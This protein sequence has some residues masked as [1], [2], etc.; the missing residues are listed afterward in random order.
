MKNL[1]YQLKQLCHQNRDGGFSTQ[2]QRAWQLSL[3]ANQLEELG[4]RR[5]GARSLKQKHVTALT[6]HWAQ[7]GISIGTRKNRLST[8]RW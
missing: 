3:I 1:N 2:S 8:L 6:R 5:M 4:F 7:Q